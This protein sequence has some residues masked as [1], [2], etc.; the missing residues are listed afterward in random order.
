MNPRLSRRV[1]ADPGGNAAGGRRT[2]LPT[3]T[4]CPRGHHGGERSN[5]HEQ[6]SDCDRPGYYRTPASSGAGDD[7][8][9]RR[10]CEP[11]SLGVRR[12]LW[13]MRG[14]L[15]ASWIK[16][17]RDL[18]LSRGVSNVAALNRQACQ[19]ELGH[20]A[21]RELDPGSAEVA[22]ADGH[23]V[24]PTQHSEQQLLLWPRGGGRDP[25]A[26]REPVGL[27]VSHDHP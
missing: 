20:N 1:A 4:W 15:R 17:D 18:S 21:S 9:R 22:V 25:V 23:A 3:G 26:L 19:F 5:D 16:S 24:A 2:W 27:S 13:A 8:A 14:L 6:R 11:T 7:P 12:F 10:L